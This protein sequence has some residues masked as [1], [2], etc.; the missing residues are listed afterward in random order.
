MREKKRESEEE[1]GGASITGAP[2]A[3]RIVLVAGGAGVMYLALQPEALPAG[4]ESVPAIEI[5]WWAF[6]LLPLGAL[7]LARFSRARPA[8]ALPAISFMTML[9]ACGAWLAVQLVVAVAFQGTAS[10][11]KTALPQLAAAAVLIDAVGDP[12][13][14]VP[15]GRS[16]LL[17]DLV[18]ASA[19]A[20]IT[21]GSLSLVV[22]A[23]AALHAPFVA[24]ADLRATPWTWREHAIEI[25]LAVAAIPYLEEV[26]FR[27]GLIGY[28]APRLGRAAAVV[29]SA[30]IF[31]A[32]HLQNEVF[33][34]RA[35]A[36]LACGILY[37]RTRSVVA[38]FLLHALFN[39]G[40]MLA[41]PW[42][43]RHIA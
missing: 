43:H 5:A 40:I 25:L 10:L 37:C 35:I 8:N 17:F 4:G 34:A 20:A 33:W 15:A 24:A 13:R 3:G 38:P 9:I 14:F 16:I 18:D 19:F 21:V 22:L 32:L 2:M 41:A 30:A 29:L 36:G 12:E 27:V 11:M 26:L 39:S 42:L 6:L 1:R 23:G 28:L 7:V 31:S